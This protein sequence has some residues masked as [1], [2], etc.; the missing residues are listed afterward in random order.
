MKVLKNNYN[1]LYVVR[2]EAVVAPYP[3]EWVCENCESSLE[4]EESDLMIG[5]LGCAYLKCPCCGHDNMIEDNENTITLTKDNVEFP[6]HFFHTS[7]ETGAAEHCSSKNVNEAIQRAIKYFRENKNEYFWF[8]AC[9]DM[10]ITVL[11]YDG[12]EDYYVTVTN[13]YYDTYIPFESSDY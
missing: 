4:Y 5:A 2:E 13:N 9:G 12:D 11:R 1:T 8:M 3:R 10:Y 7:K 6:T